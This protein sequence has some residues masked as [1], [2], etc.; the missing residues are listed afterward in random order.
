[1]EERLRKAN[2]WFAAKADTA[3]ARLWLAGLSFGESSIFFVPPDLLLAAMVF[4][5]KERWIRYTILTTVTSVAG[6][7]FGYVI[8]ALLFETFGVWLVEVYGLQEY[9]Q[10]ATRLVNE[11]VFIF[12]LTMAFTPIPFKVGVLAAGFTKANFIAFFI[13]ALVG[14]AARYALVAYVAKIFGDNADHIMRRFWLSTTLGG[15]VIIT[16]AVLYFFLR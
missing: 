13:A 4:V 15:M 10:Q 9:M 3:H 5:H 11:N 6:A 12:T 7:V 14:R 1:M 8:G 16:L 2:D